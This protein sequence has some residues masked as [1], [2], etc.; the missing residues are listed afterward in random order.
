MSDQDGHHLDGLVLLDGEHLTC[1][2]LFS[3]AHGAP[4]RIHPT[5]AWQMRQNAQQVPSGPSILSRKRRWL[6]GPH[7]SEMDEAE[8]TEAF[9]LGHCAGVGDALPDEVVRAAIAARL[10]VLA[11][12]LSG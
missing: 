9:I 12:G 3:I 5:S 1:D 4:V 8:M 2:E 10:N 7:A 11:K 6:V